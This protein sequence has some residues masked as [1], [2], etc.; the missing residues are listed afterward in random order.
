MVDGRMADSA[1]STIRRRFA[2]VDG[3]ALAALRSAVGTAL[4][5]R[6][7]AK[8]NLFADAEFEVRSLEVG[9]TYSGYSLS[10]QLD[11]M[12]L[13]SVTIVVNGGLVAGSV[14]TSTASYAIRPSGIGDVEIRQVDPLALPPEAEPVVQFVDS[15]PITTTDEGDG[16]DGS[17]IDVLVVWTPAA[18]EDAG[19][20]DAIQTV[21]DLYVAE[22]NQ[23]FADSG[24]TLSIN[25]VHMEEIDYVES[26]DGL[27]RDL[28]RLSDRDGEID[29]V[30]DLRDRVGADLVHMVVS[31]GRFGFYC[32]Q[33]LVWWSHLPDGSRVLSR[34]G[35]FGATSLTCHEG[36]FA[37]E[38]GHNFG[39]L[40]DRYL[41]GGRELKWAP[42]A[43]GYVNQ[44][45][46]KSGA[47]ADQAWM[48]VMSYPD[49]CHS[50]DFD[51]T[52]LLRFSNPEQTH[53]GDPLGVP[54]DIETWTTDGPADTSR[55]LNEAKDTVAGFREA[56]PVVTVAVAIADREMDEGQAF[57]LSADVRNRG[58]V[59]SGVFDLTFHVSPDDAVS[60]DD[61]TLGTVELGGLGASDERTESLDLT[62]P[63]ESGRYYYGVCIDGANAAQQCSAAVS[64]IVGPTVSIVDANAREG[65]DMAFSV[66]VSSSLPG[67]ATTIRW[68]VLPGTAVDSVDYAVE[69]AGTLTISAGE[70]EGTI[71]VS[72][73][74]D[75]VA[76]PDDS[77]AVR[78]VEALPDGPDSVF[79][80]VVAHTATG[81]ILDDDGELEIPDANLRLALEHA[82]AKAPGE[83][84][85]PTELAQIRVLDWSEDARQELRLYPLYRDGVDQR[86]YHIERLTGLEFATNLSVLHLGGNSL[87][88]LSPIWHLGKLRT[89]SLAGSFATTPDIGGVQHLHELRELL[90]ANTGVED[91]SALAG[92]TNLTTLALGYTPLED[93]SPLAGLRRLEELRLDRSNVSDISPLAGLGN[94]RILTLN[95]TPLTNLSPL[96][97]LVDMRRLSLSHTPVSDVSPLAGMTKIWSLSLA[98]TAVSDI[99]PLKGMQASCNV[100]YL[101]GTRITD[102]S[103]LENF[104]GL[105]ALSAVG[106]GIVDI[107]PLRH[108]ASLFHL[109]L[110]DNEVTDVA[111]LAGLT[112]L[113]HLDL[114]AN[115]IADISPLSGLTRLETLLLSYNRVS[116]IGVLEGLRGLVDLNLADNRISDLQPMAK[117][118]NLR[119]LDIG[120]NLVTDLSPLVELPNFQ[121]L[122]VLGNPLDEHSAVAHV[123]SLRD[124][125][126]EVYD[127]ML[128]LSDGS[129]KEGSTVE[130]LARLSESVS[131]DV[132][133]RWELVL[134]D[135]EPCV[136]HAKYRH[137]WGTHL[138]ARPTASDSD[139]RHSGSDYAG[140]Q[141]SSGATEE[142]I[143][144][145]TNEDDLDERHEAFVV[146]ATQAG[147][148]YGASRVGLRHGMVGYGGAPHW[149]HAQAIGLIVDESASF[150]DIPLFV[151]AS[152]T[153][154]QSFVRVVNLGPRSAAHLEAFGGV[155]EGRTSTLSLRVG[156][157][158]H[159]NSGDFEEGNVD[160]GISRGVG[161]G[162][163]EDWRLRV[164]ANDIEVLNYVRTPDGFLTSMHDTAILNADGE[165]YL[166]TF[167]PASNRDQVS[168]LRLVNPGDEAATVSIEGV[169][170]EGVIGGTVSVSLEAGSSRTISSQDL[171]SGV[172]VDGALGDGIGKWSLTLSSD[173]SIQAMSLLES[174]G[175]HITNLSTVPVADDDV[176]SVPLFPAASDELG[177]QGFARVINRGDTAAEVSIAAFDE[178]DRGYDAITLTVGANEVVHFNS[179]DLELG[180]KNKGLAGSTGAGDGDWRLKLTSE[181]DIEVLSY[182]RTSDG[183]LT[184]MH[185][186]VPGVDNRHRV[187]IFNPGRNVN[188]VS[189]L[190][191][192][193][194]GEEDAQVT[195]SGVDDAGD[196]P[197]DEVRISVPAE[198]VRSFT[199]AELESG[200]PDSEGALGVG[201]GK[202]RLIVESDQPITV[203]NLLESPTGHLTNLSTVPA[204]RAFEE[205]NTSESVSD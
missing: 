23:A 11:G 109:V 75:D 71:R 198:S 119:T 86:R 130:I 47:S 202:W 99:A 52:R 155:G 97:G 101:D 184:S 96:A 142:T 156:D 56:V 169:D 132:G 55:A 10:G 125:G 108:V 35:G 26:E 15:S 106:N 41:D 12:P 189:R 46:F 181:A 20:L 61:E 67:T 4:E 90:L 164:W 34:D 162:D 87:G 103:A 1:T 50:A 151:P 49:Q 152:D 31:G 167:N 185:D 45:A 83:P 137:C 36:T 111:P 192:I 175:G 21:I 128:S 110:A 114:S 2:R 85:M 174:P 104:V 14:R 43:H 112:G 58:R 141:I 92:L 9:R 77:F 80:S 149:R 70:T 98:G 133:G 163:G 124:K 172:G 135:A 159:F 170:D 204:N 33:A 48:T 42:Y 105:G 6:P 160:K 76:E 139:L 173:R 68:E 196:S 158:V 66:T 69:Q 53:L 179:D 195:I 7:A 183:F 60:P 32:G 63:S 147:Y 102:L 51:C 191:L 178:T 13:S 84:I 134:V 30:L 176:H 64:T 18:R 19:G 182:V 138:G 40:H 65:E 29:H 28:N 73:I 89:L 54:G 201:V 145:L 131:D 203:V 144:V 57:T 157:T 122:Y 88:D 25:L 82:L 194:A 39:L 166:P 199:S 148:S 78:L 118:R 186:V 16:D 140:Y 72:T 5:D 94:L 161:S 126:V 171:E 107:G 62:A 44:E 123:A 188:Q 165:L 168:L 113:R 129:A 121:R 117:L 22:A 93:I 200:V 74:A 81:T 27:L 153:R 115:N 3:L 177:R 79:V 154:R 193:N 91:I 95:A 37:H 17:A 143:E 120:N 190:R 24:V 205:A 187:P 197:G 38:I 59:E 150:H 146:Q 136:A 100:L 127:V 116:D 180:N 8:L